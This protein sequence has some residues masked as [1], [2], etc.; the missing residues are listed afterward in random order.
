[1]EEM[2]CSKRASLIKESP[3]LA[4]LGRANKMKEAGIDVVALA[5]GE[6]DFDTPEHI[7]E[8]AIEAI[9]S[10][11][12]KYT[13]VS[14]ISELKKAVAEKFNKENNLNYSANEVMVS[15][16]AK[17]CIYNALQAIIDEGDEVI[18]PAPYWVSYPDMVILAGGVPVFI[19]CTIEEQFKLTAARLEQFITN[20]TKAIML[21]SPSNPTGMVYSP[22]EL[23]AI[24]K[25]LEK[26][27]NIFIISDDIYEHL[28][29]DENKFTN[30]LNT[31]ENLYSRTIV[32]NGVSKSYAMTGWRIG[33][34][35][36]SNKSILKAMDNIQSQSTSNPC[37]IAQYAALKALTSGLDF[38]APMIEAFTKRHDYVVGRLNTINGIQ[39]LRAQGAFYSFFKCRDAI[40]KLFAEG[41]LKEKTD[42]SLA[43][44]LLEEH[45]VA[46]VPGSSFG[47]DEHMR[48]SFATSMSNLEKALD[49]LE[50]ALNK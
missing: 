15:T 43:N 47:L 7:K 34:V 19:P 17:Q 38:L 40:D 26:Y 29:F 13:A 46:C 36:C 25:V 31:N 12:T 11:K 10:G 9:R 6:P 30:I 2:I 50:N 8:A 44:Y 21:N 18:I 20:K 41:K 16:G 33:Y 32:I 4:M 23:L 22:S 48:I 5:A 3:T 45:Q 42:L 35:A 1:M 39:C 14:G 27:P 37:S 24:S 28:L 49:R